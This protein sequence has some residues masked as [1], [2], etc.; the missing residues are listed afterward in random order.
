MITRSRHWAASALGTAIL[1]GL[2]LTPSSISGAVVSHDPSIFQPGGTEM[3]GLSNASKSLNWSG[4]AS[5][6]GPFSS[7][8]AS[9]VEPTGQCS[10]Q[11]T[12]SSFW[13]GIDG[14]RS[15]TVEQLGTDVDCSG[16][17]P[18]YYAWYEFFPSS[19]IQFPNP[20]RPGD[21]LS[22]SVTASGDN[23]TATISD[24]NAGWTQ[25]VTEMVPTAQRF[26]AEV[27]AEAPSNSTTVLPLTDFGTVSFSHA[28]ANNQTL[29]AV[30]A[31]EIVMSTRHTVKARPSALR[32]GGNFSVTWHHS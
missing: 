10:S 3:P 8:S 6:N 13:V 17:T 26:S 11:N 12:F 24:V 14:D 32:G 23:F 15:N 7:V 25:Q 27:I 5:T 16:P 30:G 28:M 19:S 18:V 9:W 20:V 4:Y 21:T 22:A 2:I 31:R 1:L 29:S